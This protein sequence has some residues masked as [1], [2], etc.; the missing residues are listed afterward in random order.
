[1]PVLTKTYQIN[2]IQQLI[3]LNQDSTNFKLN[4]TCESI[5]PNIKYQI[6]VISQSELDNPNSKNLQF[7][8]V[9][10]Q[11]GGDL[12]VDKNIY[13]NYFLILKSQTPCEVNVT[14]NKEEIQPA[15]PKKSIVDKKETYSKENK[16]S[17]LTSSTFLWIIVGVVA[18]ILIYFI[19]FTDEKKTCNVHTPQHT[20]QSTKKLQI[21]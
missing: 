15:I 9:V 8:D 20:P 19:F 21:K 6:L 4:F 3:D 12:V 2:E 16:K 1:M 14:I 11:M 17:F 10:G 13:Q 5:K 7:K 18:L